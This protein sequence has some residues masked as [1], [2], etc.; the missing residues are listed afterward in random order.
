M[1]LTTTLHMS[2]KQFFEFICNSVQA[3]FGNP[4]TIEKG[5]SYEKS[6]QTS[7]SGTVSVKVSILEYIPY[8]LYSA[9]FAHTRSTTVMTY[10]IDPLD[11]HTISLTYEETAEFFS[12]IDKWNHKIVTFLYEKSKRKQM[13]KRIKA[14]EQSITQQEG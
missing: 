11:D 12:K 2:D 5:L 13:L 14:M 7:L 10:R 1:Q 4:I 3:D 9:S 6:L 8:S